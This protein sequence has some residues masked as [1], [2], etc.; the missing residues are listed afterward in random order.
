M[1]DARS[2]AGAAAADMRAATAALVRFEAA[3]EGP[4]RNEVEWRLLS[5]LIDRCE[6]AW[7]EAETNLLLAKA[8]AEQPRDVGMPFRSAPGAT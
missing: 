6:N 5:E 1:D 8:S 2:L 7:A 4:G 3:R